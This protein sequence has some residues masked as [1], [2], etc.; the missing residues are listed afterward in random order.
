VILVESHTGDDHLEPVRTELERRGHEVVVLD[1]GRYPVAT[2]IEIAYDDG[3]EPHLGLVV[4]GTAHDL[5]TATAAWWRRPMPYTLDETLTD[6]TAQSFAL[7]E[8]DEG[9]A[10]LR[11][12]L[13]VRWVN[14]PV[15]DGIAVHKPYQ[16]REARL[17]GLATPR[18][19]V[20]NDPDR[21]RAFIASMAPASTVYKSFRA[22][23]NAWRETRLLTPA[24]MDVLDSV[25]H[26]PV[27]FQEYVPG[28]VD[29]RIT[30]VGH[31]MFVA[32]IRSAETAY[33]LDFRL[34]LETVP[35]A[36]VTLP[37]A[38]EAAVRRLMSRLGLVYGAIDLRVRPDGEHVFFEVN[39]S[40]QWD[41]VERRTGLPV[42]AAFADELAGPDRALRR[43]ATGCHECEQL[44]PEA[45]AS[46]PRSAR[47]GR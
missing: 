37:P 32:E 27:I 43:P 25:R 24:E 20:T 7:A 40:G 34:E 4:D 15:R 19:L 5:T 26:A 46:A 41:F 6:P 29:L 13:Q 2:A 14:D 47:G 12:L 31:R 23:D 17:A 9:L 44:T 39:P 11:A 28:D 45:S 16:L 10:G 36:P 8:C 21:A 30:V 22:L 3:P 18:T 33:A 1:S 42:T 38:V 35:M